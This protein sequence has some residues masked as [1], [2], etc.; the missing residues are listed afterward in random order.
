MAKTIAAGELR[1]G[2]LNPGSSGP[3]ADWNQIPL[4]V[5]TGSFYTIGEA[6]EVIGGKGILSRLRE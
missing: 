6:K 1:S 5:I 2:Q 3:Q 4:I